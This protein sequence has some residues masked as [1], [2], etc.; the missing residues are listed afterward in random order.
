MGAIKQ[1][2]IQ[3]VLET[4]EIREE[5]KKQVKS[6]FYKINSSIMKKSQ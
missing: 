1:E 5:Q 3:K 6:I 2:E 4:N